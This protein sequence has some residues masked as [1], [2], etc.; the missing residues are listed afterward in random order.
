M[1]RKRITLLLIS[2]ATIV[3]VLVLGYYYYSTYGPSEIN[4]SGGADDGT[5]IQETVAR[6]GSLTVSVSGSGQ[7]IPTS[8][9]DLG[10]QENGTLIELYVSV[11]DQV[12]AGDI[13]AH[14][15]IDKSPVEQ[16]A[17]IASAELDLLRAQDNLYQIQ[18][19]AQLETA[20]A[21]TALEDAQRN[22]EDLTDIELELAVGQQ[23]V[24]Q[25]EKAIEDAEMMLY[26]VNSTPAQ[27][28]YDI[29][30]AS[31][32]F[33][34]KD[35]Q[36]LKDQIA[37]IENQIKSASSN[38]TRDRLKQ[39]LLNLELALANQQLEVDQSKYKYNSL[40]DPPEELDL[41]LAEAQ[42]KAAQAQL[43]QA[44]Q[45]LADLQSGPSGSE[46]AI[47][48]AQLAEAQ[49]DWDRLKDGPD[50]NE[51]S[52][53]EALIVK[54]E[55]ALD[56]AQ[57]TQLIVDLVAP[58]AGTITSV[59]SSVGDRVNG[60]SI[61]SL[62]DMTQPALEVYLDEID[63]SHVQVGNQVSVIFDAIPDVT[64]MGHVQ[65]VDP[66]L[67]ITNNSSALKAIIH[68]DSVPNQF[69]T[70][71]IGLNAAVEVIAGEVKNTVLIPLEALH[72]QPDDSYLVYIKTGDA[73]EPRTVQVGLTDPT[74][75]AIT[76]GLQPGERLAI[77]GVDIEQEESY[78]R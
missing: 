12:Q 16:S 46:Y 1:T 75:A 47:A 44:Q 57:Q 76:S 74:T 11:G 34:E 58:Q 50:S 45:D 73:L 22:L 13:L 25:V 43:N 30:N 42:L 24:H 5:T 53:A 3:L 20:R 56:L 26:I 7:L 4:A 51:I 17:D 61:L 63:L 48:E 65:A 36:E 72:I 39:Q 77:S 55:A 19:Y 69:L 32:M 18:K 33:K 29:A 67:S 28:A 21:L 64:V 15:L 6:S 78:D 27:T 40:D 10:F 62:A 66:R 59:N 23:A 31:L 54:A 8:T 9:A 71:P 41:A 60:K 14:L 68:L 35:L 38:R 52:L 37:K 2:L 49:S 70:L